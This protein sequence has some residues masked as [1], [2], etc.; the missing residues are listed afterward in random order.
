MVAKGKC[1]ERRAG[2]CVIRTYTL[3]Y[4]KR[5]TSRTCREHTS[6][7]G[8][9]AAWLGG[10]FGNRYMFKYDWSPFAVNLKLSQHCWLSIPQHKIKS[11]KRKKRNKINK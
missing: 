9:V 1:G 7:Q 10:G 11:L 2:K 6:A 3:L 8:S 5:M 4:L